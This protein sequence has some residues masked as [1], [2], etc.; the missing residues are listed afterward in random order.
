M[1]YRDHWRKALRLSGVPIFAA[2]HALTLVGASRPWIDDQFVGPDTD[3]RLLQTWTE[4]KAIVS[5]EADT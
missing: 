2:E 1:T 4:I 3:G 5:G